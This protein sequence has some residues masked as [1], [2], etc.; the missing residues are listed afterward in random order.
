VSFIYAT[1]SH[2]MAV[3]ADGRQIGVPLDWFPRLYAATPAE[4]ENWELIAG[5]VGIRWPALDEDISA[6]GLVAGHR[7][8]ESKT[9]FARWLKAYRRGV[10][11]EG[12]ELWKLSDIEKASRKAG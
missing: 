5:G 1:E 7:S 2:L 3:L 8:G 9:S 10:R 11:G 12:L 4:R 6:E